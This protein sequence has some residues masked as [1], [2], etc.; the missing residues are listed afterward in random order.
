MLKWL[1]AKRYPSWPNWAKRPSCPLQNRLP[2]DFPRM[3]RLQTSDVPGR[4]VN[5]TELKGSLSGPS[6]IRGAGLTLFGAQPMMRG[7]AR[8][9]AGPP[10]PAGPGLFAALGGRAPSSPG[11]DSPLRTLLEAAAAAATQMPPTGD[12]CR[13]DP[14]GRHPLS[15]VP[16][17]ALGERPRSGGR[18]DGL[19]DHF[20]H[21]TGIGDHG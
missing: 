4:L 10:M 20:R 3:A 17:A 1:M 5:V 14:R 15:T 12:A 11:T 6:R 7:M 8:R 19:Q 2:A 18:P 9:S 21:G 16:V 13:A